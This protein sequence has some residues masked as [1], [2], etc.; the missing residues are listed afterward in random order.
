MPRRRAAR[1]GGGDADDART[2]WMAD[3]VDDAC[4]MDDAR[5]ATFDREYVSLRDGSNEAEEEEEEE[6]GLMD[7]DDDSKSSGK[8][9]KQKQTQRRAPEAL[10][11]R[12]FSINT[13]VPSLRI[14]S[15]PG[16]LDGIAACATARSVVGA[17]VLTHADVRPGALYKDAP[18]SQMLDSGG[19]LVELGPGTR[20][21]VP[22]VHLFDRA[23]RGADEY[24]QRVRSAKYKVGSRIAVRCLTVD[25]AARQ[26]VRVSAISNLLPTA[27]SSTGTGSWE[28][29]SAKAFSMPRSSSS[30]NADFS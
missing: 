24:R 30:Q 2:A 26:C 28:E 27:T 25:P 11:A 1:D 23:S 10:F 13:R 17:P 29:A 14:L 5:F 7:V 16:P 18:V 15:A 9:G 4:A 21:I 19:V 12:R 8:K 20:G 3:E 22:A 6:D